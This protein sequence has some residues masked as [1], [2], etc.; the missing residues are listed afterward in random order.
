LA[1][2]YNA[3]V[4]IISGLNDRIKNGE[5]ANQH[6][7]RHPE[8]LPRRRSGCTP[9]AAVD[10]CDVVA[11]S[12]AGDALRSSNNKTPSSIAVLPSGANNSDDYLSSSSVYASRAELVSPFYKLQ[13]LGRSTSD[14]HQQSRSPKFGRGSLR[15]DKDSKG[16]C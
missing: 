4:F 10:G 15:G 8:P 2:F 14:L 5:R 1:S 11:S 7:H 12:S 3:C 16:G 9:L 6:Q 13:L